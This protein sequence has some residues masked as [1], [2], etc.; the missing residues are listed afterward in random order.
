MTEHEQL[1]QARELLRQA[2]EM[3]QGRWCEWGER[4]EKVEEIL[5]QMRAILA[6]SPADKC[7]T[8]GGTSSKP[9]YLADAVTICWDVWHKGIVEQ[10]SRTRT[11]ASLQEKADHWW[12]VGQQYWK[13][14]E[15]ARELLRRL[16]SMA[17]EQRFDALLMQKV[18][19]ALASSPPPA[20]PEQ[21]EMTP[22]EA[23][24][25]RQFQ[26]KLYRKVEPSGEMGRRVFEA[27]KERA[28]QIL[29]EQYQETRYDIVTK[30]RALRYEE[31]I[32]LCESES[33]EA[34]LQS[35]TK[36]QS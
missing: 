20:L 19:Q 2:L 34:G 3:A 16:W 33:R 36:P 29:G 28:A 9:P 5:D 11:T 13:Q 27:T 31:I 22:A 8:C 17:D 30:I 15:Q 24:N 26:K 14:L 21:R 35:P 4:A 6:S 1:E 10:V 23:A 18:E 25:L 32:A 7:P 12:Y